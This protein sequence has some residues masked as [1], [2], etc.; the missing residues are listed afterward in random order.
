MIYK[1]DEYCL[2]GFLPPPQGSLSQRGYDILL[3]DVPCCSNNWIF[4]LLDFA[5]CF[6]PP[7]SLPPNVALP[8]FGFCYFTFEFN[9]T[10]FSPFPI[11]PSSSYVIRPVID[12]PVSLASSPS[13]FPLMASGECENVIFL[14]ITV[15]SSLPM[16]ILFFFYPKDVL[17]MP[18]LL[19][20]SKPKR[21]PS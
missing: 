1:S 16:Q 7:L 20:F 4:L 11:A 14:L 19:S 3:V 2:I 6:F 8:S 17:M 12:L 13:S 18:S 15:S 21:G 9:P 10:S 5:S